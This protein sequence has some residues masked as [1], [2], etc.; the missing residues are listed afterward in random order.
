MH[1]TQAEFVDSDHDA[2]MLLAG[3]QYGKTYA[4]CKRAIK[5]SRAG[6]V[7]TFISGSHMMVITARDRVEKMCSGN[8][9][10]S[11]KMTIQPHGG[12]P[13]HF[14]SPSAPRDIQYTDI[15]L[16]DEVPYVNDSVVTEI[17]RRGNPVYMTGTDF[18]YADICSN[19]YFASTFDNPMVNIDTTKSMIGPEESFD[20]R[21]IG[22]HKVLFLEDKFLCPVCDMSYDNNDEML[23]YYAMGKFSTEDCK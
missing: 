13:I 16:I 20:Y 15:Y 4:L 14:S 18:S 21:E 22:E 6:N 2:A 1:S 23:F 17:L 3:R 9:D 8:V 19:V 11:N 10:I 12:A 7:V 5:E